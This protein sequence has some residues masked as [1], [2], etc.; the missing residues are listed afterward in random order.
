[1]PPGGRGALGL[2]GGGGGVTRWFRCVL[3]NPE[4]LE[5]RNRPSERLWVHSS[6][7]NNFSDG[8]PCDDFARLQQASQ[9][10]PTATIKDKDGERNEVRHR[11]P[12]QRPG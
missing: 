8:S 12:R 10:V 7:E 1:M 5:G 11:L 2:P 6:R 3:G 4:M 9:G